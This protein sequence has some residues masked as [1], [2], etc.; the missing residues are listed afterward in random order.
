MLIDS[1]LVGPTSRSVSGRSIIKLKYR[2]EGL[3]VLSL[4]R[5]N[6]QPVFS[7]AA[8]AAVKITTRHDTHRERPPWKEDL[9]SS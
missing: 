6:E 3:R 1:W 5:D 8:M 4:P 7:L 2:A 9:S